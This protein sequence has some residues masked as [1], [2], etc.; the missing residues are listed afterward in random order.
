MTKGSRFIALDA[1]RGVAAFMVM[2]LHATTPS[3]YPSPV[4]SAYLA[5][6]LFFLLSGFVLAH[7]YGAKLAARFRVWRDFMGQRF[8]RLWPLYI[9][10]SL[11]GLALHV[12][13]VW[14]GWRADSTASLI[15]A[16]MTNAAFLPTIPPLA[17]ERYSGF[18]FNPPAWSL[19]SEMAVNL[20]FAYFAKLRRLAPLVVVTVLSGAF[21]VV[22]AVVYE[23]LWVGPDLG[24]TYVGLIRATFSFF[25]GVLIYQQ[26]ERLGRLGV[27]LPL[28]LA[29][30]ILVVVCMAPGGLGMTTAVFDLVV[31]M[32]L[33]PALLALSVSA[34]PRGMTAAI[35]EA[36]GKSS[37]PLY[38]IHWPL[39]AVA[40][41][42]FLQLGAGELNEHPIALAAVVL[43]IFGVA[44]VL[45]YAD[46]WLRKRTRALLAP[47]TPAKR[48]QSRVQPSK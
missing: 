20:A 36:L 17:S 6:D 4:Q 8:L 35:S 18:P 21:L 45:G 24:H 29:L 14:K 33:F 19:F 44:L 12:Y 38:I 40:E 31:V 7:A 16:F 23:G 26:R 46:D 13:S 1:L 32:V 42:A 27:S 2:L 15:N 34:E 11:V 43:L 47:A 30:T 10:G 5:V 37:Y 3:S 22:A 41:L 28:P 48:A 25:L 39:L 9:L